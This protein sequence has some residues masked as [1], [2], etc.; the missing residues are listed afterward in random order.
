MFKSVHAIIHD[1]C[2]RNDIPHTEGDKFFNDLQ[3]EAFSNKHELLT[4]VSSACQRLWTSAKTLQEREF[5]SILNE[6]I[7]NDVSSCMGDVAA[8]C[9]GINSLCVN[10]V[11][12]DLKVEWPADH[13]LY[14]GGALPDDKRSFFVIG[15]VYRCPMYLATSLNRN[16]SLTFCRR[17]ALEGAPPVL[18]VLHLNPE[19]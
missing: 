15:K 11:N 19:V 2:T 4:E 3:Q 9:R 5:C 12:H 17:V 6:T 16:V 14:R 13:T 8:I 7:R 10:R 18:W 1:F